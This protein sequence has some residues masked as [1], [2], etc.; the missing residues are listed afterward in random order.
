MLS[1]SALIEQ[2]ENKKYIVTFRDI[3]EAITCGDTLEEARIMATDALLTALEFYFEDRRL[4]PMPTKAEKGEELIG[5]PPIAVAKIL[6]LNE[7]IKQNV[8]NSELASRMHT[9]SAYIHKLIH[10]NYAVKIDMIDAALNQLGKQLEIN[11]APIH[12]IFNVN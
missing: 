6:L 2:D 1:Y 5:L 8:S 3:P 9:T 10:L 7:L 11:L 4:I 12:Y